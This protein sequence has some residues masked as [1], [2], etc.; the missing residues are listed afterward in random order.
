MTH[1]TPKTDGELVRAAA[2]L[3]SDD[4]DFGQAGILYREV[5]SDEV[6]A[7]FQA[8]LLGQ[9]NGITI[10]DIRERFFQYWTNVDGDLGAILRQKYASQEPEPHTVPREV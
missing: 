4:D 10:D 1:P 9:A 5:F 6:R 8:T 7:Q 2:T 3:R